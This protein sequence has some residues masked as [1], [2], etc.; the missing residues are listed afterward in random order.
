MKGEKNGSK[1]KLIDI[2]QNVLQ[3]DIDLGFLAALK[4]TEIE[5]L[6]A[7]VRNRVEHPPR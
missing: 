1:E 7:C 5:T 3:T 6:V 2:L 4:K